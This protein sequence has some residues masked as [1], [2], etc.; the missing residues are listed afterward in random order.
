V[1]IISELRKELVGIIVFSFLTSVLCYAQS[2]PVLSKKEF[3]NQQIEAYQNTTDLA[4]KYEKARQLYRYLRFE[5]LERAKKYITLTLEHARA[6][7]DPV[8]II[9]AYTELGSAYSEL[10]NYEAAFDE[11]S[12]AFT[13]GSVSGVTSEIFH[14]NYHLGKT[15]FDI[16]LP[17]FAEPLIR[18]AYDN[19]DNNRT[20]WIPN[21]DLA[22]L[23]LSGGDTARARTEFDKLESTIYTFESDDEVSDMHQTILLAELMIDLGEFDKASNL[24]NARQPTFE[25]LNLCFFNG[26]L[27]LNKSR[28]AVHNNELERALKLA[29]D[30]FT[31]FST[32]KDESYISKTLLH[33][34]MVHAALNDIENSYL[35]LNEYHQ[36]LSLALSQQYSAI[37]SRLI[38]ESEASEQAELELQR[39]NSVLELRTLYNIALL[40]LLVAVVV[41]FVFLYRTYKKRNEVTQQLE[42][43][44]NDKNHF[45]GVVSHDLRSPLNSVMVLSEFMKDDPE[46]ID[47]ETAKEYGSII[48]SS[49]RQMQHLLNNMLDVNKIESQTAKVTTRQLQLEETLKSA[50]S[51]LSVLGK[52]KNIE[53]T[54]TIDGQ[55]PPVLADE[56]AV[57]RILENLVNNAYKFSTKGSK[58]HIT[59]REIGSQ[60]ELGVADEGPGLSELDKSK[61]FKKFEKLSANPTANEKSTGL[62]LYIVKNL[63]QQMNGT[64]LVKSEQGKG[65]TFKVLLNKAQF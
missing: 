60:V 53:T 17:A 19:Y 9:Y 10:G 36:H 37:G 26:L 42:D 24:M 35:Y 6:L 46:M 12:A 27:N 20:R 18:S 45:I 1:N 15:Y 44:N 5:D 65:T 13:M 21:F 31:D 38:S 22:A 28:I 16:Q 11:Y 61:L 25:Q 14:T 59:A 40:V 29:N 48:Y 57:Y 4:E 50:Y 56:N 34:S 39:L 7:E 33:L 51:T 23:Y 49:T 30:A 8:R 52:D 58:V 47:A 32:H 64:I 62:G 43:L 55:L 63:V 3:I 54:L 41:L 2:V